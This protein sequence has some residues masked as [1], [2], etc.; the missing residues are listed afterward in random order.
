MTGGAACVALLP[1]SDGYALA[2]HFKRVAYFFESVLRSIFETEA[3]L[4]D[5]FLARRKRLQQGEA[6]CL[7]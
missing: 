4:D 2:G 6:V 7:C 5:F 3:Q 1:R